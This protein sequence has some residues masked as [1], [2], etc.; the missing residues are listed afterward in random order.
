NRGRIADVMDSCRTFRFPL[1]ATPLA[2][3]P[4][5]DSRRGT[6][7]QRDVPYVLRRDSQF[8][9]YD[10]EIHAPPFS[11]PHCTLCW[12]KMIGVQFVAPGE[13]ELY[14]R[15]YTDV[16]RK[17]ASAMSLRDLPVRIRD[18][19]VSLRMKQKDFGA[20]FGV[21]QAAVS[22]WEK[23]KDAKV[24][25]M[26]ALLKMSELAPEAERAWWR[27]RAAEQAGVEKVVSFTTSG[28]YSIPELSRRVPLVNNPHKV[29]KA[30]TVATAD[31]ERFLSFSPDF[32]PEGGRNEAVRVEGQTA[33]LV[34]VIDV[35]HQDAEHLVDKMVAVRTASGIEVR[36]LAREDDF[37]LLLPFQPGQKTKPMRY[38]GEWS[39]VGAVRWVGE[40]P[41]PA[42]ELKR[43]RREH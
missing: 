23:S 24:P 18:L 30:G 28:E 9:S 12:A 13:K 40:S 29:G 22:E 38:K 1:N 34:A 8:A 14:N 4:L 36:W 26:K 10:R 43:P 3:E 16:K 20:I 11:I 35:S 2:F 41:W 31:I 15:S 6:E 5:E 21:S 27:D 33:N 37:Y 25:G 39:I 32:F 7:S 42:P 19:R 17:I